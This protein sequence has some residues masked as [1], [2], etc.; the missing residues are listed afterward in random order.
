M[1]K[2]YQQLFF[3]VCQCYFSKQGSE[4]PQLDNYFLPH[5]SLEC[6]MNEIFLFE[7]NIIFRSQD[8]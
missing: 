1:L 7:K 2:I 8:I 6:I 4:L 5:D 3:C